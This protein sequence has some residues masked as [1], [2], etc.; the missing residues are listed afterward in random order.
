[1]HTILQQWDTINCWCCFLGRGDLILLSNAF[2]RYFSANWN[3]SVPNVTK[4]AVV[5]VAGKRYGSNCMQQN[6]LGAALWPRAG[7]SRGLWRRVLHT[8]ILSVHFVW[9]SSVA[10]TE[11]SHVDRE[12]HN[13]GHKACSSL[14]CTH[15]FFSYHGNGDIVCL[16]SEEIPQMALKSSKCKRRQLELSQEA[17][18]EILTEIYLKI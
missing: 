17:R 15:Y 8:H 10:S 6:L 1:M 7:I 12:P 3:I 5:L 11:H 4:P 14:E 16:Y 2:G 18:I 13:V 9:F